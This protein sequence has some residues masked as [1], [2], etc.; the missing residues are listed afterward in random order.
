MKLIVCDFCQDV[1]VLK[2]EKRSCRCEAISG[3]YLG[4][5][6]HV[7]ITSRNLKRTRVLGLQN[8]VRYGIKTQGEVWVISWGNPVIKIKKR[9]KT[10]KRLN[11]H[12]KL[13]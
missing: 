2:Y 9:K 7:E 6:R 5:G 3:K 12:K 11:S 4:D 13:D 1:V 10:K 8:S